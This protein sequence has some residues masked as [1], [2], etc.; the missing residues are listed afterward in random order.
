MVKRSRILFK[1]KRPTLK[2]QC[3]ERF[4]WTSGPTRITFEWGNHSNHSIRVIWV[5]TLNLPIDTTLV[6]L[7]SWEIKIKGHW[8]LLY[9]SNFFFH[10]TGDMFFFIKRGTRLHFR[11]GAKDFG[12]SSLFCCISATRIACK[13]L[14]RRT[15]AGWTFGG[16]S[17]NGLM[18]RTSGQKSRG[19]SF[20]CGLGSHLIGTSLD[21]LE[22]SDLSDS[23][24]YLF[25]QQV[26]FLP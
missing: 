19:C 3:N 15:F 1:P 4:E 25:V 18:I 11:A 17:L 14:G 22:P 16:Y 24:G 7:Q 6:P 13:C 20:E 21:S 9:S 12:G 8:G 2:S 23:P 5:C 26:C 10:K